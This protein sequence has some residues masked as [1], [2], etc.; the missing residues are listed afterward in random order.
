MKAEADA[1]T[2]ATAIL[3]VSF[4]S[5]SRKN[6]NPDYD[7]PLAGRSKLCSC[8]EGAGTRCLGCATVCETCAEVCPNR[9][10]VAIE[11]PGMRERQIVHIDGMCN[12]CG[13]CAVFCPYEGR[14][15]KDKLTLF[16]SRE[17]FDSSEN[18]G[19]LPEAGMM[20]VRLDGEVASFDVD[21]PSCGL[22]EGIRLTIKAVLDSYGYL[23]KR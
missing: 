15:Y 1:Q 16:W 4:D 21:D 3:G 10:N 22:P 20:L 8:T 12:E 11:V 23:L 13:N 17:D 19:F 7:A 18:E 9:A 14:P 2:I 5:E 6:V